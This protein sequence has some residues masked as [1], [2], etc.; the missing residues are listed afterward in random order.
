[1]GRHGGTNLTEKPTRMVGQLTEVLRK[2][3]ATNA[4]KTVQSGH[5]FAGKFAAFN[6]CT[7]LDFSRVQMQSQVIGQ[8]SHRK[9]TLIPWMVSKVSKIRRPD[10]G[11]ADV[12]PGP[13][14]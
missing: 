7:W 8:A 9:L 14:Q 12:L 6:A 2:P 11:T 4:G 5:Y 1:M 10:L 3:H 13:G